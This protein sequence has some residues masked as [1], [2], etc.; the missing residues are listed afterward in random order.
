VIGGRP[1]PLPFS[2][3]PHS[4][5]RDA[6]ERRGHNHHR[7]YGFRA[8]GLR[9]APEWRAERARRH[10]EEQSD[11]AIQTV[12]AD[13]V[14]IASLTLA[15]TAERVVDAA[16]PPCANCPSCTFSLALSGKSQRCSA[17]PA[18]TRGALAIVTDVGSGMR[19]PRCL[20]RR[21]STSR[22]AKSCGPG[23]PGLALSWQ[24]DLPM[25]VTTKPGH[26]GEHV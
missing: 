15:M 7:A 6:P 13:A 18:P 3:S 12:S 21:M 10:C 4:S 5:F 16:F 14:W 17:R 9:V 23:A 20:T 24:N 8:R 25:T 11:E 19:W 1:D 26:R 22:T 2:E